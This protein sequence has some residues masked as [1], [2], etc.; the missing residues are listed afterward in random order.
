MSQ[1]ARLRALAE[2]GAIRVGPPSDDAGEEDG[3]NAA[4]AEYEAICRAEFPGTPPPFSLSCGLWA[5]NAFHR[6]CQFVTYRNVDAEAIAAELEKPCPD[7]AAVSRHYSVDLVFRFLPDLYRL[8]HTASEADPLCD[9]LRRYGAEWPLSSV[10]MTGVRPRDLGGIVGH[11]GL[12]ALYVDR[13]IARN[14][15][16]RLSE[17]V[18][19]AAVRAA[20]GDYGDLALS[21]TAALRGYED[22]AA[23]DVST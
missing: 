18:I 2:R 15:T 16:S 21:I 9:H 20:L 13:L 12:L 22:R 5:L 1:S 6:A 14:D 23:S 7:E 10:G 11:R 19:R 8:S 17:P 4:L 3:V